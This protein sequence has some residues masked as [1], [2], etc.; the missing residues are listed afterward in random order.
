MGLIHVANGTA[1]IL[2][3]ENVALE[4]L[5][6]VL[7]N[8]NRRKNSQITGIR[9]INKIHVVTLKLHAL[10]TSILNGILSNNPT[11]FHVHFDEH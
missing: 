9:I 10:F 6:S 7:R 8:I 3:F 1:E 4:M 5:S 11:P 2:Q